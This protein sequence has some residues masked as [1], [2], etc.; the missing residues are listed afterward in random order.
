[1]K[2]YPLWLREKLL[3]NL[4]KYKL[5]K[6]AFRPVNLEFA[7]KVKMQLCATDISHKNITVLG[8]YE[9]PVT[10]K[11]FSLAE[12]GGVLI[13]VGANYGYYSLIWANR[14]ATNTVH[15]FEPVPANF[16]MLNENINNNNF[17]A[18]V[19]TNQMALSDKTGILSFELE[20]AAGNVGWGGIT[21]NG[22]NNS[23]E[24]NSG[25]LDNYCREHNIKRIDCLKIDT[26]GADL[27]VLKGAASLLSNKQVKSILYE[28]NLVRMQQLGIEAGA[29]QKYLEQFGYTVERIAD[30][31]YFAY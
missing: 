16:K 19:S 28:E 30:M 21:F 20:N 6:P 14:N 4:Y 26:E 17:A 1:M 27:L 5:L 7:P 25:T 2:I 9:L 22:T 29:A 23:I 10:K 18:R 31:E 11:I 3:W 12:K 15:S 8:F 13:D 24:V